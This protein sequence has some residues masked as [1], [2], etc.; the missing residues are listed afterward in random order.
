VCHSLRAPATSLA[1]P[2]ARVPLL[3]HVVLIAH[4]LGATMRVRVPVEAVKSG[5]QETSNVHSAIIYLIICPL[6]S[7]RLPDQHNRCL[8][9]FVPRADQARL[10]LA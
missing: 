8:T 7:N 9:A 2:N 4:A 3:F 1:T 10:Y 6:R 5:H